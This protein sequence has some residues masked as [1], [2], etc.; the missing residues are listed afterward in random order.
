MK[1]RTFIASLAA[2]TGAIAVCVRYLD[3]PLA[4]AVEKL[5]RLSP[6]WAHRTANIP[7][8]LF[9]AACSITLISCSCYLY[10]VHQRIFT[11]L[12][13]FC[14]LTAI[15][16]PVSYAVKFCLQLLFGRVNTRAWLAHKQSYGFYWLHG[17]NTI[18]GF[19]SGHMT[20]SAALAAG[21]WRHYP[22]Y[23]VPSLLGALLL[24]AALIATNYHFL[25]DVIAGAFLGVFIEEFV[26]RALD[27]RTLN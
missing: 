1:L 8:L 26:A 18:G 23:R 14:H 11:R 3:I 6:Y 19:P 5:Y 9:L 17:G 21:I 10:L 16:V 13:W 2:V 12:T 22:R 7:D 27:R 4:L 24:G 15:T 25:G 20:V